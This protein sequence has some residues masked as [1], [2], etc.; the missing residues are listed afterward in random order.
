M[1]MLFAE[2][3]ARCPSLN[4]KKRGDM[5][6][7]SPNN[8]GEIVINYKTRATSMMIKAPES[9]RRKLL[10]RFAVPCK[11]KVLFWPI[12]SCEQFLQFIREEF[13]S[14]TAKS[15][16]IKTDR[17]IES[18]LTQ[19]K[20]MPVTEVKSEGCRRKGQDILRRA[21]IESRARCE[22]S[23]IDIPDLLIASHIRPWKDCGSS[24][25]MRLDLENVLLLSANWDA[26][27]DKKYISFDPETGKMIKS[28]RISED[29]LRKFGVPV[30]WRESVRIPVKTERRK[31]YLRWHNQ[32]IQN[33][34]TK[35]KSWCTKEV[36]S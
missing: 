35:S 30:D 21:L 3:S 5:I 31:E 7:L 18:F 14:A 20:Q 25:R 10:K 27:F 1:N 16:H 34:D 23:R 36:S 33:A 24:A 17:E 32:L 4:A 11:Q 12:A 13:K 9:I 19:L 26:L 2:L 22:I 8:G 6:V 15:S 29:T 28:K